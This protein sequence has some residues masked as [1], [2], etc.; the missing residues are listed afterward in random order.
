MYLFFESDN[1]YLYDTKN[2]PVGPVPV[3]LLDRDFPLYSTAIVRVRDE[4]WLFKANQ[5]WKIHEVTLNG[6]LS[7]FTR[8]LGAGKG[9]GA[10]CKHEKF[11]SINLSI[12]RIIYDLRDRAFNLKNL[13]ETSVMTKIA[14]LEAFGCSSSGESCILTSTGLFY[15][16]TYHPGWLSFL[17]VLL[18]LFWPLTVLLAYLWMRNKDNFYVVNE[19][20]YKTRPASNQEI[21][22]LSREDEM[23]KRRFPHHLSPPRL[24]PQHSKEND[25]D[26]EMSPINL[27]LEKPSEGFQVVIDKFSKLIDTVK[28]RENQKKFKASFY[29]GSPSNEQPGDEQKENDSRPKEG[30]VQKYSERSIE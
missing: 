17:I 4:I 1:I 10:V 9:L 20:Q 19:T 22:S 13:N 11:K 30:N 18:L 3:R 28:K 2:E 26:E 21:G 29:S 8:F 6:K 16:L 14:S 15:Y 24:S 5:I 27:P 7:E 12:I 25:T 23:R